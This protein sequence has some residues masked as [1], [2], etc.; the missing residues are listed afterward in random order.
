MRATSLKQEAVAADVGIARD[1]HVPAAESTRATSF[2]ERLPRVLRS[3]PWWLRGV[4][5]GLV[6]M[7]GAIMLMEI[8]PSFLS[9][10]GP[11]DGNP[12]VCWAGAF[13]DLAV[14]ATAALSVLLVSAALVNL[15]QP[16][17]PVP[18]ALAVGVVTGSLLWFG[19]VHLTFID[20]DPKPFSW[21]RF[22]VVLAEA[23]RMAMVWGIAAAAW[24]FLNRAAVR[25]ASLRAVE[26][27]R[28]QL[29]TGMLE[30]RLQALQAQVE[31]HFLFNTLA[32]IKRL[33]RT[34]RVRARLMLDSFRAYLR[35]A[36]PQMRSAGATLGREIDLVHAYL[37]VQQVRM[38]RRLEVQFDVPEAL[39][40]ETFPPMMLISLV[41]NAI[42]HGLNPLPSGGAVRIS[43]SHRGE[44]LEVSVI[45]TGRGMADQ[46]G[47]GVGL[48][49]IRARLAALFGQ[50]GELSLTPNSPRGVCATIRIPRLPLA[51]QDFERGSIGTVDAEVAA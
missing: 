1:N 34:D 35:S 24:Y 44:A 19:L 25:Q 26:L 8:A 51:V 31:P 48:S 30:A 33:Y 49:N 15:R 13:S 6:G 45:D 4:S 38:G 22:N 47:S 27:A 7:V 42:K 32:H 29:E 9:W 5:W 50:Q 21:R 20:I 46:I 11:Q 28:S 39:R 40:K 43:A 23:R 2:M 41:E 3:E 10:L 17:V 18:L 37:D 16:R 12:D 36:L 14:H